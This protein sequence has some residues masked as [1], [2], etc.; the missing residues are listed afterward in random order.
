MPRCL[1]VVAVFR[2]VACYSACMLQLIVLS[3]PD[4]GREA[5]LENGSRI[6]RGPAS[7]LR[8]SDRSIS[9]EHARV[10]TREGVW[11]LVDQGS[12]NGVWDGE[13]RVAELR[14][15]DAMEVRL[16]EVVLRVRLEKAAAEVVAGTPKIGAPPRPAPREDSIQFA[17]GG[18]AAFAEQDAE[19]DLDIEWSDETEAAT[20]PAS[21]PKSARPEVRDLQREELLRNLQRERGG[22]ARADMSQLPGWVR[23]VLMLG[24]ALVSAGVFY[25]VMQGIK[26]TRS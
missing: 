7:G 2:A 25:A 11:F 3:G 20:P 19:V 14:L 26:S 17:T 8:L 15:I 6:G 12:T 9:R 18:G 1:R 21:A 13:T 16:G 24:V 4:E 22:L 10:E 5:S 23:A